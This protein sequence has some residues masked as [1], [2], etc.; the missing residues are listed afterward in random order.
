MLIVDT[1]VWIDF[2]RGE[3]TKACETL[4]ELIN[5]EEE[6][7]ITEIILT[8]ILQ[9]IKD[10]KLHHITKE[11]LLYF[12]ILRPKGIETYIRA[13]EIFRNCKKKGKTV[14]KTIDCIIASIAIEN[15]ATIIHK[16]HDYETIREFSE[17]KTINMGNFC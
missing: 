16:D 13:S 3:K 1:S 9:G 4:R 7:Y 14:R 15:R 10:D 2:L 17:L 8:E 6:I 5:S 12:Q 11:Y